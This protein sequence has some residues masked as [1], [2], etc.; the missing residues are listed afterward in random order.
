MEDADIAQIAVALCEIE[1][2]YSILAYSSL[3]AWRQSPN[4][5]HSALALLCASDSG[6]PDAEVAEIERELALAK[7]MGVPLPRS[8]ST[9]PQRLPSRLVQ[10]G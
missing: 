5:A 8:Q 10:L 1:P 4:F 6:D 2:G 3:E 7:Q 9:A